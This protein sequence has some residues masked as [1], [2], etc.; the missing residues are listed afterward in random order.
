[1][2]KK[3]ILVAPLN[4]GLGHA[5]RCIPIIKGL[6]AENFEPILASDGNALLLLQKEFPHLKSFE[7]PSYKVEYTKNG[8]NFKWKMM[9]DTP[10]LLNA[11]KAEKKV[12]KKLVEDLNLD[13]IISD[14]RF[15]V[16][17]KHLKC[18]FI[19]HQLNVL[20]GT[21]TYF[22]SKLHQK[23]IRKFDEC[24]IPD[25]KGKKN[26]SGILGHLNKPDESVKYL[27]PISRFEKK[28]LPKKYDY[29]LLLSGPE[30]QRTILE[31]L[32]LKEFA[33]SKA[34]I[35]LVRGV[36]EENNRPSKMANIDI[37]NYRYG[38]ELEEAVNSSEVVISRSGY[39]TLLDLAKLEKKAFFIPTPGQFEQEYLA[40]RLMNL[41]IAP[42]CKQND[43]KLSHLEEIRKYKGLKDIGFTNSF[44]EFFALF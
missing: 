4:W 3:R 39:T 43:F 42:S 24:W 17:Y 16:R 20:S 33:E 11:I 41:G 38:K 26:L 37:E 7:L 31:E 6:E 19:T 15:G 1:M 2:R 30:P 22:S 14:N 9:W 27:G 28:D 35:I 40:E 32:L 23:Y 25:A 29:L 12:T 13:G 18:V 44:R 5:S 8:S 34:K 36:I 21:T 10:K